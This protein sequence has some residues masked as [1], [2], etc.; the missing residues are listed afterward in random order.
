MATE[1]ERSELFSGRKVDPSEQR[2]TKSK[3]GRTV[4]GKGSKPVKE[5]KLTDEDQR[6]LDAIKADDAAVDAGI[7]I[8][9]NQ[10]E[11]LLQ[12]SKQMGETTTSQNKKLDT[13]QNDLSKANDKT[14][15]VNQRA[16]LFMLNRRQKKKENDNILG[17]GNPVSTAA[18]TQTFR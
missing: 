13:V 10:V 9:G 7:D 12:I 15:T 1:V 4:G 11:S 8:L 2:R 6:E 16:K 5:A 3:K 18:L 17:L 14:H